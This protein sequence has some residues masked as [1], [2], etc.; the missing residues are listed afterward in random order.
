MDGRSLQNEQ[1]RDYKRFPNTLARE[2]KAMKPS[3]RER[4]GRI[5]TARERESK[6]NLMSMRT[7]A[8]I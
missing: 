8:I 6:R 5:L 2:K 1:R 4:R 3:Q 7:S